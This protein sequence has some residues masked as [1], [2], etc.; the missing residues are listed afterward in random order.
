MR[1]RT[2]ITLVTILLVTGLIF[3][4]L[5]S[6]SEAANTVGDQFFF[7][8]KQLIWSLIGLAAFI[9]ASKLPLS[10]VKRLATPT[11]LFFVFLLLITL[12]PRF[13]NSAL[14]ARRW[15]DLGIVGIQP[16]E[17]FKL[18]AIIFFSQ[19]FSTAKTRN[20]KSLLLFLIP[21][22]ILIILEPNMSTTVLVGAIVISLF[23]LANG[24]LAAIVSLCL[25]ALVGSTVLIATSPYRQARFDTASYHSSQL[26]LTLTSGHLTGKGFANS[27]QKYRFLPK[28]SSDSIL[29]VIGEETGFIGTS[30]IILAFFFL[31]NQ[32]FSVAAKFPLASFENLICS[33]IGCWIAYQSLI[34]M[35]AVVG[36]IPLTGV[37]L[38]LISYGG[39]SLTAILFGV[40]LVNNLLYSSKDEVH[41]NH[42]HHR[43]SSH[44]R[45]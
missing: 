37:T 31:I 21:P 16:S 18:A 15:L 29:A 17:L 40:G 1:P 4:S 44:S 19:L 8:K 38:P 39:S 27:D 10:L 25:L 5:S 28:I 36:L 14:G 9:T 24:S 26:T 34:N 30:L 11:Y 2:L 20:I 45:H 13:G 6:I 42:R 43:Q 23:Y 33:G 3:I 12:I 22:L 41:Q 35:S 7:I 32:I